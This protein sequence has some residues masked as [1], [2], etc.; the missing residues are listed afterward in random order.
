MPNIKDEFTT[1]KNKYK[2]DDVALDCIMFLA[3]G[4]GDD[5]LLGEELSD[6][7]KEYVRE[8]AGI[9]L[10]KFPYAIP[11]LI[12]TYL[13]DF[14][15]LDIDEINELVDFEK[16]DLLNEQF[17]RIFFVE[18]ELRTAREKICK[19]IV[20]LID[21][22]KVAESSVIL[23]EE[24][25]G[26]ASLALLKD[27]EKSILAQVI[28]QFGMPMFLIASSEEIV[29]K[30]K[31]CAIF[32]YLYDEMTS[33]KVDFTNLIHDI[34]IDSDSL[35]DSFDDFF[36]RFFNYMIQE[37]EYRFEKD[38]DMQA[39]IDGIKASYLRYYRNEKGKI[40]PFLFFKDPYQ[41]SKEDKKLIAKAAQDLDESS[42]E[43]EAVREAMYRVVNKDA[44]K[45]LFNLCAQ[46]IKM[47]QKSRE[48]SE[49]SNICKD[50]PLFYFAV[51]LFKNQYLLRGDF[52]VA[53]LY[54]EEKSELLKY[55][56]EI[57]CLLRPKGF[58]E[59]NENLDK[60]EKEFSN[61]ESAEQLSKKAVE[62]KKA[63]TPQSIEKIIQDFENL[64]SFLVEFAPESYV[65]SGDHFF[66]ISQGIEDL[67]AR[68]KKVITLF[69]QKYEEI[70][71]KQKEEQLKQE[72]EIELRELQAQIEEI[73]AQEEGQQRILRE[74]AQEHRD[75]Q[76]QKRLEAQRQAQIERV[77]RREPKITLK[78]VDN[79]GNGQDIVEI[80]DCQLCGD[81][82][83]GDAEFN[84]DK[85]KVYCTGEINEILNGDSDF[86]SGVCNAIS[87]GFI[88][89]G[90][91]GEEGVKRMNG[92]VKVEGYSV[93]EVKLKGNSVVPAFGQD[94][95]RGDIR[96]CGVVKDGILLITDATTHGKNNI[97]LGNTAKDIER[98]IGD[99]MIQIINGPDLAVQ[100]ATAAN[101]KGKNVQ[102]E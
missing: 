21:E 28:F 96:F 97:D 48:I 26:Y 61:I 15:G 25:G 60:L 87:K 65:V 50:D 67:I 46:L 91:R 3:N 69:T 83:S 37:S 81:Q 79:K 34:A 62:Y 6:E 5:S 57:F 59:L 84:K 40:S 10:A 31:S 41:G 39:T 4:K 44:A 102:R 43:T 92:A 73:A 77:A 1:W 12:L 70:E 76:E 52:E 98:R 47:E 101:V 78:C 72:K 86:R 53:D 49:M 29:D 88:F 95:Q 55:L 23:M 68:S 90:S 9:N 24:T 85:Y 89:A 74:V 71:L 42:K 11:I 75:R 35:E 66:E 45:K 14:E 27:E 22:D 20:E 13:R 2:Y 82:A 19:N 56:H 100:G 54:S 17:L 58:Y 94:A 38:E 30:E 7:A 93:V 51:S 16:K 32:K 63:K 36:E 33:G 80:A 18:K 99:K 8:K 64:R